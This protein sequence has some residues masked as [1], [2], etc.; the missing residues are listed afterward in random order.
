LRLEV[1]NIHRYFGEA[2]CFHLQ[3]Q[4]IMTFKIYIHNLSNLSLSLI[5]MSLLEC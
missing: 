4:T 1:V 5:C 2:D 3:L